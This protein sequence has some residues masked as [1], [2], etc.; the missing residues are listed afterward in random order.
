VS[1]DGLD[2][3]KADWLAARLAAERAKAAQALARQLARKTRHAVGDA[4][5]PTVNDL[6]YESALA[7]EQNCTQRAPP[8]FH[9]TAR[10]RP[11]AF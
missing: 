2:P 9:G 8:D 4:R 6:V 10:E 7:G 1:G 3:Q 11:D 5:A